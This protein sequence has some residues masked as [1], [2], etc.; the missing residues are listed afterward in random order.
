MIKFKNGSVI[1]VIQN[2]E[3]SRGSRSKVYII[4]KPKF[5]DIFN[6]WILRVKNMLTK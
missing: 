6:D 3:S 5:K 2:T 1:Q 4:G